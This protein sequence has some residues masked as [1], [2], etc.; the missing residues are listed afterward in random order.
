MLNDALF[1]IFDVSELTPKNVSGLTP[2]ATNDNLSA[3][4]TLACKTWS[5]SFR[6]FK[7]YSLNNILNILTFDFTRKKRKILNTGK[8]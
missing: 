5:E 1:A 6:I 3:V 7:V 8:F 4:N 2:K